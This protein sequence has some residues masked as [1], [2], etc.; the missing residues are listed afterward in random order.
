MNVSGEVFE[1]RVSDHFCPNEEDSG[2]IVLWIFSDGAKINEGDVVA[3]FRHSCEAVG[4]RPGYYYSLKD[5][6]YINVHAEG[7]V[8]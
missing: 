2:S 5:N 6:F 7:Q 3:E 4:I 1:W 8:F